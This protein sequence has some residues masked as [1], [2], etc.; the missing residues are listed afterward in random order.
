MTQGRV[1]AV[2]LK[3]KQGKIFTSNIPL[4]RPLR[5]HDW[6]LKRWKG[7]DRVN[8]CHGAKV[9][10]L[11]STKYLM[12]FVGNVKSPHYFENLSQ[13]F[14]DII[15]CDDMANPGEEM[16]CGQCGQTILGKAMK[17]TCFI[18]FVHSSKFWHQPTF[19]PCVRILLCSQ[20]TMPWTLTKTLICEPAFQLLDF[21]C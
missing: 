15:F 1:S 3:S 7:F 18:W 4:R 16:I 5:Q 2:S 8:H 19:T 14:S 11:S 13:K 6:H 9:K 20:T 10:I 12:R 21:L 17:V